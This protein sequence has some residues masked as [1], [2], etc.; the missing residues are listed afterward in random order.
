MDLD[1]VY[2]MLAKWPSSRDQLFR[3]L[4]RPSGLQGFRTARP[5]TGLPGIG[6][7]FWQSTTAHL[8]NDIPSIVSAFIVPEITYATDTH[9]D[10][11]SRERMQLE[12]QRWRST[13]SADSESAY[14][15]QWQS[16]E[17]G[18]IEG[19]QAIRIPV[20]SASLGDNYQDNSQVRDPLIVYHGTRSLLV[21][22]I[23]NTGIKPS[24]CSHGQIGVWVNKNMQEALMWNLTFMDALPNLVLEISVEREAL[25]TNRRVR[26][27]S[28]TRG[29][30][31]TNQLKIQA[32]ILRI[33][34]I[35]F[36]EF[37]IQ[38]NPCCTTAF[39]R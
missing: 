39:W 25:R 22:L 27:G 23:M 31:V 2:G 12:V 36:C 5:E 16:S 6:D 17:Y 20:C 13:F 11:I 35:A 29:V 1:L 28:Q 4:H 3:D 37:H 30:V 18:L 38:L 21:P 19:K 26:A 7:S 9:E 33:P 32:I 24:E 34:S 14:Q 8:L 15:V 10:L